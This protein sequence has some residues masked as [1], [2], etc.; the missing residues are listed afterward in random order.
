MIL[1]DTMRKEPPPR[2]NWGTLGFAVQL[3]SLTKLVAMTTAMDRHSYSVTS[4]AL[5]N[6]GESCQDFLLPQLLLYLSFCSHFVWCCPT[7]KD[8]PVE[9]VWN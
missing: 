4:A 2:A 8:F 1:C 7:M 5:N 3:R 9:T 6:P